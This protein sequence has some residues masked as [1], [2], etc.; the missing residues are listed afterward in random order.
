VT[1]RAPWSYA[2]S[3]GA[4]GSGYSAVLNAVTQL[5]KQ[6]QAASDVYYYGALAPSAT[7]NSFCQGGCVTGLSTV[8]DTTQMASFRASVGVGF[9]GG[10]SAN[11]AAHEVGHAHGRNHAP[12]GG[13]SGVDA[14][15]PYTGGVIGVWGYDILA[16]TFLA[17]SKGHD[18][19]GYCADD[20]VSDYTF[21]ALFDRIATVNGGQVSASS[22]GQFAASRAAVAAAPQTFRVATV[23][24]DGTVAW[25]GEIVD[26]EP[27]GGDAR[28][29]TF[30]S[31]SGATVGTHTAHFYPYDHLPGG[32]LVVP[33]VP[34]PAAN[35]GAAATKLQVAP[36]WSHVR[37]SGLAAELAR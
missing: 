23:E 19:M 31:A 2:S 32:V 34:A 25:G 18:M 33:A 37:I 15:F 27:T 14:S 35:V 16:K 22:S 3:I 8:V 11:T 4:N 12:C 29:A 24:G 7:F 36:T 30:L 28:V 26:Q 17:P 13:T 10:D 1:A 9:T 21:S 20:W 6:D 5:R